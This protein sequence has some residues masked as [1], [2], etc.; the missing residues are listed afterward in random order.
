MAD[1]LGNMNIETIP[2]GP[3]EENC[4]LVWG[5]T[6][7]ALIIDPGAEPEA[8]I[9]V[10]STNNLEVAAYLITHGHADHT[11]ALAELHTAYP[12]PVAMHP[13]DQRWAFTEV[14]QIPPHYPSPASPPEI[15]RELKDG[16]H[17]TDNDLTYEIIDTPGHTPGGVCF[18]FPGEKTLFSGDTLFKGSVGRTDLPSGDPRVLS[19]SLKKLA[20]LPPETRVFPG[21]GPNTT[22]EIELRTNFFLRQ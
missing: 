12:A 15:E 2:V 4:Y 11:G 21:H 8:V 14:N 22:I 10:L 6:P 17:W 7:K 1:I 20:A 13:N 3:Y 16:Q 5:N 18:Y 9:T 19:A